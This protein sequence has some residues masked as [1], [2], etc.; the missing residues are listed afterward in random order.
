MHVD[1]AVGGRLAARLLCG[2]E[3]WV[4][5]RKLRID[6]IDDAAMRLHH[7]VDFCLPDGADVT[8]TDSE[9]NKFVHL[10]LF[11]LRKAPQELLDFD[12]SDARDKSLSLPTRRANATLSQHALYAQAEA[13]LGHPLTD[14]GATGLIDE[15]ANLDPTDSLNKCDELIDRS[16]KYTAL[17]VD[18]DFRFLARL[19]AWSSIV[20]MPVPHQSGEQIFKLTYSEPINEWKKAWDLAIR[21]GLQALPTTVEIPFTGAQ[22]FHLEV[23]PPEGMTAESGAIAVA[24]SAGGKFN[25]AEESGRAMHLYVPDVERGRSGAAVIKLRPQRRGFLNGATVACVAVAAV[26]IASVGFARHLAEANSVVPSLLLFLPGLLATVALQ[27]TDHALNGRVL[28]LI[29]GAVGLCAILAFASAFW[30]LVAPTATAIK[31]SGTVVSERH[32]NPR[33]Q[34]HAASTAVGQGPHRRS[35]RSQQKAHSHSIGGADPLHSK[36]A[37][38]SSLKQYRLFEP[39]VRTDVDSLRVGW[40]ILAALAAAAALLVGMARRRAIP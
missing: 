29:R 2:D 38:Q 25:R 39:V 15:V 3:S 11:V 37:S 35:I 20:S 31:K 13:V 34:G 10:P 8:A 6:F 14:P 26:L 27:P 22:S 23:H 12:F 36:I 17:A 33:S 4:R 32:P 21:A 18:P 28:G 40:G 19:I 9:E 1:P 30:L 24:T 5:R 16:G 7:S